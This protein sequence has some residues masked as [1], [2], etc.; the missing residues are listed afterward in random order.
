MNIK[1]KKTKR[2]GKMLLNTKAKAKVNVSSSRQ[3]SG[4]IIR[5][6]SVALERK[7][8]FL[9]LVV[10]PF[11]SCVHLLQVAVSLKEKKKG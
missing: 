3:N 10:R 2:N 11:L 4:K 5:L 1:E 8:S 6:G 7:R 9:F